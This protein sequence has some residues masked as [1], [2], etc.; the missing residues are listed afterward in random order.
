MPAKPNPR[1][2]PAELR[3][4]AEKHTVTRQSKTNVPRNEVDAQR[5]LHE[6]EVHQ[7]ELEMQNAEL[8]IARDEA[9]SVMEKYSALYDFAPVGYF[10]ILA[11]GSIRMVNLAGAALIGM[12]RS[13]VVG[14][15]FE[16]LVSSN[17]RSSFGA[18]L[19]QVFAGNAAPSIESELL[20][21]GQPDRFVTINAQLSPDGKE[22]SMS[23]TDITERKRDEDAVRVSEIR[24]RRLFET[25][26]DGV[27]LM[28]PATRKIT[29]AN[30]FMTQLLGYSHEELVGK[31]LFEIGLLGDEVA[32]QEMFRKLKKNGEVRYEDLP[33]E[34]EGGRHQEVEVVANL[35][36]ENG[37][38][39]IQC[40]IRDITE[41]KQAENALRESE[42][43]NRSII[44]S[45]SDCLKV[46]DLA[47]NLLSILQG[48]RELLGIEDIR[49]Y[50]NKSWIAFWEGEDRQS[51]RVA[52]AAAVAGGEGSFVGFF[53]TLRDEPKWW[54][55][56]AS[57]IL[58][59]EGKPVRILVV[60][61][62]ITE[63]K[64]A[65]D[66][67]RRSE[68]LFFALIEQ[69]PVGV[70]V[71]DSK[72]RLQQANPLAL[73]FF[74]NIH[75]LIGRD[76]AEI[77]HLLWAKR[78]ADTAVARFRHTFKTGESFQSTAITKR[79][80]DTGVKEVFEWQI[81]RVILPSGEL[82]LVCFFNNITERIKADSAQ[83]R[84]D[85]MA[86]S[87][88]KLKREI[89]HR[90]TVEEK[91]HETEY[92]QSRL[93]EHS[94]QQQVELRGM[95]HKIL[96]AQ[97][98]ERK[99]ISRE[100]HDVIAQTL[101][102]IN[103][104]VAALAN[105]TTAELGSLQQRIADT[106]QMVE[107]SVEIVHQFARELRPTVLDDLGLIPALQ[108]LL[109]GFME[110]TGIRVSL[111]ISPAIEE[112]SESIRTTFYRITQEALM[113]VAKHAKASKV[114]ISIRRLADGTSLQIT[115]DGHGFEVEEIIHPNQSN[116]LGLLG[117]RE[118]AEMVGGVFSVD[119]A[120]G[121]P[122]TIRVVIKTEPK[123]TK[124]NP[125][126]KSVKRPTAKLK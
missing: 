82:A 70:Y 75:P 79:R 122:T 109:K 95:S 121:N 71:V 119:S 28:D 55:V 8:R 19:H 54:D 106:H 2:N 41:R 66:M 78:N 3:R 57:P 34:S 26:H 17:L 112:S 42:A 83:R 65:E 53:R 84:L 94:L 111:K 69:V 37:R 107:R 12:T 73:K 24:Y 103:V 27:L 7:I 99:R 88:E 16:N 100:L 10:T 77:I 56:R 124:K 76:Y 72:L 64:E 117:M 114:E 23:V 39:V 93:L 58:D 22:C 29:D 89:V 44:E 38:P 59:K 1:D 96:H 125:S 35:Y 25:A 80:L 45:S 108:A 67:L 33:L 51:A 47:G 87:N 126:K 60:S 123:T 102:G 43:F 97:E 63:R 101:V 49:P 32:S 74:N 118:R 91:L 98:D 90:L 20:C 50:L 116:R 14:R 11:D 13:L 21:K 105:E 4:R 61:R 48:A 9:E 36:Q 31:E 110:T 15:S 104:H 81:Q 46:L 85:L 18:F 30:P 113:N 40:N 5:L 120:P 68:A 6:L 52:L 62:D 86:A 92:V 115:D